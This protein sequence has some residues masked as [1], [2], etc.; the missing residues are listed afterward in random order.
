MVGAIKR[1]HLEEFVW[2]NSSQCNW[3]IGFAIPKVLKDKET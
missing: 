1:E 2:R 3:S